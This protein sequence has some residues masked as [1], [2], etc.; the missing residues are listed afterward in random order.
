M[1]CCFMKEPESECNPIRELDSLF[2]LLGSET[3]IRCSA[4]QHRNLHR[5]DDSRFETFHP[6]FA[7]ENDDKSTYWAGGYDGLQE[8]WIEVMFPESCVIKKINV[9]YSFAGKIALQGLLDGIWV[10][11]NTITTP[12]A[13][14][15]EDW[16]SIDLPVFIRPVRKVRL[17]LIEK[18]PS[19]EDGHKQSYNLFNCGMM[20]RKFQLQG[21]TPTTEIH[22]DLIRSTPRIFFSYNWSHQQLVSELA[23]E[24]E[25][26]LGVPVWQDIGQMGGGDSL[27]KSILNGIQNADVI[28]ICMTEPYASSTNCQKEI[29]IASEL[30]I[31]TILLCLDGSKID[32][33]KAENPFLK[34]TLSSKTNP[35]QVTSVNKT[36]LQYLHRVIEPILIKGEVPKNVAE[37]MNK[38]DS[39]PSHLVV[40]MNQNF[41]KTGVKVIPK[42][43]EDSVIK[44]PDT[45]PRHD[46]ALGRPCF[47]S[48]NFY[49]QAEEWLRLHDSCVTIGIRDGMTNR[50]QSGRWSGAKDGE[51][52]CWITVDL[53]CLALVDEVSIDFEGAYASVY[54]VLYEKCDPIKITTD[55]SY[56]IDSEFLT[57]GDFY[58][59]NGIHTTNVFTPVLTR[60]IRIELVRPCCV[61]WGFSVW[62]L[63]VMG[64]S[65]QQPMYSY[66]CSAESTDLETWWKL[67]IIEDVQAKMRKKAYINIGESNSLQHNYAQIVQ[68]NENERLEIM[69]ECEAVIVIYSLESEK[70]D[71]VI[72]DLRNAME[73][74]KPIIP[75]IVD[76]VTFDRNEEGTKIIWPPLEPTLR[77]ACEDLIFIDFSKTEEHARGLGFLLRA[78]RG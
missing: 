57:V 31:P 50:R 63:S 73:M 35:V 12:Q 2:P 53:G 5:D 69:K 39:I 71:H 44:L 11:S 72:N 64:T 18:H 14:S 21:Y 9:E 67:K 1:N 13:F 52:G 28:V 46:L 27:M 49:S 23:F 17:L 55:G 34:A 51:G 70:C 30:G 37:P 74:K 41:Q 42:S 24:T 40:N 45:S 54:R 7:I 78:L 56:G 32:R 47:S 61:G 29:C 59:G 68:K 15:K 36:I 25:N 60:A 76:A 48:G 16:V 22:G 65:D 8:C 26:E 33:L 20:V 43:H 10:T 38:A 19:E 4:I 58:G 3:S 77:K 6:K 62:S 75:I 66:Y